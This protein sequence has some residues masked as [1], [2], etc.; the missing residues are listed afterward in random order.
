MPGVRRINPAYMTTRLMT[1]KDFLRWA[2]KGGERP[3]KG[4]SSIDAVFKGLPEVIKR[5]PG[6]RSDVLQFMRGMASFYDEQAGRENIR[7][8]Q[9]QTPAAGDRRIGIQQA[10]LVVPNQASNQRSRQF[11]PQQSAEMMGVK[12]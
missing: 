2:T 7:Q 12:G 1:N 10:P 6:I 5:N 3:R 9:P 8:S 11:R 4:L